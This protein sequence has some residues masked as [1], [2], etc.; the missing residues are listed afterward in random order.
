M[1]ISRLATIGL[2]GFTI[3]STGCIGCIEDEE[4]G[5]NGNTG[6]SDNGAPNNVADPTAECQPDDLQG[7][8]DNGDIDED[9]VLCGDVSL[10]DTFRTTGD[11]TVTI[12]PGTVI[13]V[14]VDNYVEFGYAGTEVTLIAEGTAEDPI[15]FQGA[16]PEA[17]HW[18]TIYINGSVTSASVFKHVN[19]RHAGSDDRAALSIRNDRNF[20]FSDVL[21]EN[22]KAAG[23]SAEQFGDPDTAANL[24]VNNA[25][26]VAAIITSLDGAT[27][28]PVGGTFEGNNPDA[29][30]ISDG[31]FSGTE[32]VVR[33]AGIPYI[34]DDTIRTTSDMDFTIEAGV[35]FQVGTDE[36]IEFGY[37]GTE[38]N[39]NILGTADAPVTFV[40]TDPGPGH[41]DA[42]YVRGTV[43]SSSVIDYIEVSHAGSSDRPGLVIDSRITLTNATFSENGGADFSVGPDG[44][45]PASENVNVIRDSG[46]SAQIHMSAASSFPTGGSYG[47]GD[48]YVEITNG[49]FT[50]G[51]TVPA[52]DVP[53]RVADTIRTTGDLDVTFETGTVFE[54]EVDNYIEFGYAGTEVTLI[55]DGVTVR[56]TDPSAGHWDSLYI[57]QS[58][59]SS[60]SITNSTFQHA[61]SSNRATITMRATG[62]T[63]EGNTVNE[64]TGPCINRNGDTT[65]YASNNTLDCTGGDYDE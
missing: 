54:V 56:G 18:D 7:V 57:N 48:A 19:I 53:Y 32:V 27:S 36:Y 21:I 37:A 62:V 47:S 22:V 24:T 33:N 1:R 17:G 59:T 15:T 28:F 8:I 5:N 64:S 49:D 31:D 13:T 23:V 11:I 25:G 60:S 61:G 16:T 30:S 42:I 65:D 2:V 39:L 14:G 10:E 40:G 38:V 3:F 50:V 6:N 26:G 20:E 45:D 35:A 55:M 29:I 34:V 9:I 41:W 52:I 51:G 43:T 4:H 63:F 44:L 12:R 58:V 46:P